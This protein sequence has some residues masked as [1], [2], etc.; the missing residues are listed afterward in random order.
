MRQ[1]KLWKLK[2]EILI[3]IPRIYEECDVK[4]LESLLICDIDEKI[5]EP[6]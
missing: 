1:N 4:T 2:K 3:N 5:M 6:L